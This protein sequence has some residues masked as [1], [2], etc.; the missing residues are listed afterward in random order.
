METW[1][2]ISTYRAVRAFLDQPLEPEHLE[3]ILRAGRR[4]PSSK[5]SQR[6]AFIVCRDRDR[7]QQLAR[8]GPFAGH[9]AS[10]GAAIALV[11]PEAD[12]PRTGGWI[13]LDIGQVAQN[14][15]LAAWDLGIGAVHAS[16]HDQ[17]LALEVLGYPPEYRCDL[18]LSLGYPAHPSDL[19]RPPGKGGRRPLDRLVHWERW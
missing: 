5:N 16:V 1:A 4:A 3:R 13:M 14:M 15:L 9:L 17:A 19:T 2:A 11:T 12:D 10:A 7:L 6:W 8:V 18:I